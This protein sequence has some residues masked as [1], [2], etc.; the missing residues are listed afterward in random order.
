M[1]V[2][3]IIV[4]TKFFIEI[5]VLLIIFF[6]FRLMRSKIISGIYKAINIRKFIRFSIA[7][8]LIQ[9]LPITKLCVFQI[10]RRTYC[11]Q[12]YC[13]GRAVFELQLVSL[14]IQWIMS[15]SFC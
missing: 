5:I 14:V 8:L 10:V 11:V 4:A 9:N 13:P 15:Q 2:V 3:T 1:A 12:K 7:D 6:D